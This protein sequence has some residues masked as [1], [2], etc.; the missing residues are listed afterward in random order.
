MKNFKEFMEDSNVDV[1]NRADIARKRF[2]IAKERSAQVS[3]E[4]KKEAEEKAKS[5][6]SAVRFDN[7]KVVHS[8]S[9]LKLPGGKRQKLEEK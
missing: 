6:S 1:E 3:H 8:K 5:S 4:R 7:K 9:Q 2:S